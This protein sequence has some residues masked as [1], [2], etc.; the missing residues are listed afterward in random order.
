MNKEIKI[1]NYVFKYKNK[2]NLI[3]IEEYLN[4]DGESSKLKLIIDE[5]YIEKDIKQASHSSDKL[6]F[7]DV[8][9]N[10]NSVELYVDEFHILL[11]V[12]NKDLLIEYQKV[13]KGKNNYIL[14]DCS[15]YF[16]S[17][18]DVEV[19]DKIIADFESLTN[20]SDDYYKIYCI[21]FSEFSGSFSMISYDYKAPS[22]FLRYKDT[23]F[24]N[25]KPSNVRKAHIF[26]L[27]TYKL[28]ISGNY[29]WKVNLS[30]NK[31]FKSNPSIIPFKYQK[32]SLSL[33]M[34]K[35]LFKTNLRANSKE[36]LIITYK[37]I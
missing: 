14:F 7:D 12:D 34:K 11:N 5:K 10:A 25:K 35:N 2:L 27:S 28:T 29:Y 8:I 20:I 18:N 17:I 13:N 1:I 22:V 9:I 6:V 15:K 30:V 21:D 36:M 19:S 37:Y 24:S 31:T 32:G 26:K 23:E 4:Y 33:I 3:S 16:G